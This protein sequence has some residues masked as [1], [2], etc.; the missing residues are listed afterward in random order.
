MFELKYHRKSLLNPL[1][2]NIP[3][4]FLIISS[5]SQRSRITVTA[6]SKEQKVKTIQ[7]TKDL[8]CGFIFIIQGSPWTVN[9][10]YSNPSLKGEHTMTKLIIPTQ[11]LSLLQILMN[12]PHRCC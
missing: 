2:M 1:G 11:Y 8:N 3:K 10:P 9:P 7:Q 12:A 6:Q 5:H 4:P